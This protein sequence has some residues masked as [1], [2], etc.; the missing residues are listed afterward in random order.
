MDIVLAIRKV[1]YSD[2]CLYKKWFDVGQREVI[3]FIYISYITR[4]STQTY[5]IHYVNY[6]NG[7]V[8]K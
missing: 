5:H 4:E 7:I 8:D 6:L 3:V 1:L 2:K